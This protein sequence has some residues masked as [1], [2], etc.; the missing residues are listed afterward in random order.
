MIELKLKQFLSDVKEY[1]AFL[2]FQ[3][4]LDYECSNKQAVS[5]ILARFSVKNAVIFYIVLKL[6]VQLTVPLQ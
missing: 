3:V 1:W 6:N 5:A 2:K 4:L